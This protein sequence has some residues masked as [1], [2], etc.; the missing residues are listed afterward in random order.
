MHQLTMTPWSSNKY[1]HVHRLQYIKN[2]KPPLEADYD[3]I[4]ECVGI[5]D[6]N[7]YNRHMRTECCKHNCRI[8]SRCTNRQLS[9]MVTKKCRKKL[10]P[11]RGWG[12]Q[13]VEDVREGDFILEY[14]GEAI[15]ETT[16]RNRMK[17]KHDN[18]YL[19]AL[20]SGWYIDARMV[21]NL[22]RFINHSCVPNCIAHQVVV[23]RQTRC[24]IFAKR[25]IKKMNF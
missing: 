8:G 18:F 17:E 21:G 12:L 9:S 3:E 20:Q 10:E 5:C 16:N 15:D 14:A 4:C 1:K 11:N 22:S 23:K 13:I 6:D 7:C 2:N 24:G 19:M 25:S